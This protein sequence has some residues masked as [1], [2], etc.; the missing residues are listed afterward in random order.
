[1]QTHSAKV[2]MRA[3]PI[4]GDQTTDAAKIRGVVAPGTG[5]SPTRLLGCQG[6]AVSSA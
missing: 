5:D 2:L 3:G 4:A 6:S 1:M